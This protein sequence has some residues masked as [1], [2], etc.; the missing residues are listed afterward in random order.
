VKA[1]AARPIA[2]RTPPL[3]SAQALVVPSFFSISVRV[4]G[5]TAGKARKSPPNLGP[6]AKPATAATSAIPPPKTNRLEVVVEELTPVHRYL[7]TAR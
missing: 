4:A 1:K 3:A 2:P 7:P 5:R 6:N